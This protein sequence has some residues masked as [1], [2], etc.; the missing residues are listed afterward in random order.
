MR[1]G[2]VEPPTFGSVVQRSIQLSYGRDVDH[3]LA[4]PWRALATGPPIETRRH[5]HDR[6]RT[7]TPLPALV[8][9]TS[10]STNSST[11][12]PR[13][14]GCA[15]S[16][17][18]RREP[19]MLGEGLEPSRGQPPQDTESCASANSAIR[20]DPHSRGAE[21]PPSG[22]APARDGADGT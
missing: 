13:V 4:A 14:A 20:A 9:Q 12:A 11:W 21:L 22:R 17:G 5:A 16:P 8:P 2:G 1:P 10:L 7:C 3:H 15:G 6:T 18:H 19:A